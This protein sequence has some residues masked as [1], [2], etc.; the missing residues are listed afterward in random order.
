MSELFMDVNVAAFT[1]NVGE[2]V[3]FKFKGC[4]I[5]DSFGKGF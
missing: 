3:S 5:L 1:M 2:L 4:N